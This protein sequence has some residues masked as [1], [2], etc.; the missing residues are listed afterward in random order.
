VNVSYVA[1]YKYEQKGK[2]LKKEEEDVIY[3][4]N[5]ARKGKANKE[6]K[7]CEEGREEEKRRL[8]AA[9]VKLSCMWRLIIFW[10][11]SGKI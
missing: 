10:K 7:I 8:A 3:V 1:K 5:V 9:N 11:G 6:T 4:Y 2:C